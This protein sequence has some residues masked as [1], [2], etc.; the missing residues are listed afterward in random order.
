M[1]LTAKDDIIFGAKRFRAGEVFEADK[2][3]ASF[4]LAQKWVKKVVE[5]APKKAKK[6]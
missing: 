3:T 6:K 1:K 5:E 2:D 4:L